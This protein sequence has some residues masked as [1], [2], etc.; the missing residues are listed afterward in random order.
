MLGAARRD[1]F[2]VKL[3]SKLVHVQRHMGGVIHMVRKSEISLIVV[4]RSIKV[5]PSMN[6]SDTGASEHASTDSSLLASYSNST[7]CL[8]PRLR[9]K[10]EQA[11]AYI[12]C[13]IWIHHHSQQLCDE[14]WLDAYDPQACQHCC[15]ASGAVCLL[16]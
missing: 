16:P 13:D 1:R 3:S 12:T 7:D 2:P 10:A 15:P 5:W 14:E 11:E 6:S 4:I 8:V 9:L